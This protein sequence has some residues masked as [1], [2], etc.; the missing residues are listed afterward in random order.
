[1][2]LNKPHL[3][4]HEIDNQ[5]VLDIDTWELTDIIDDYLTEECKVEYEYLEEI[6]SLNYGKF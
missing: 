2:K 3:K 4:L 6:S 1:M 5:L